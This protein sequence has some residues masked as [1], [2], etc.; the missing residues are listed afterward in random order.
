MVDGFES[1]GSAGVPEAQEAVPAPAAGQLHGSL[2][3][4]LAQATERHKHQRDGGMA[5][6][7]LVRA[8]GRLVRGG[9]LTSDG[10]A[11]CKGNRETQVNAT[12]EGAQGQEPCLLLCR[13]VEPQPGF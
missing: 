8:E 13:A 1:D 9:P 6:R 4:H 3:P 7:R 12:G 10:G 5:G 11:F 2:Q